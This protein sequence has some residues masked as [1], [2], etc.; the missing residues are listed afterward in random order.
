MPEARHELLDDAASVPGS[1]AWVGLKL[2]GS[3]PPVGARGWLRAEDGD[4]PALLHPHQFKGTHRSR[5][6][7]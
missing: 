7:S 2:G 4:P 1:R 6:R 3:G 5:T